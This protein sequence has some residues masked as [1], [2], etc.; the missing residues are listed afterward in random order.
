MEFSS[1][2]ARKVLD[3]NPRTFANWVSL[4]EPLRPA[5]GKGTRA[6]FSDRNLIE[7]ALI[8]LL[9]RYRFERWAVI[10]I[11]EDLRSDRCLKAYGDV[12]DLRNT[13]QQFLLVDWGV[14]RT[15]QT[16]NVGFTII[17]ELKSAYGREGA[18]FVIDF[19]V[20]REGLVEKIATL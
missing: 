4:I 14:T 19:L 9:F 15:D 1:S 17:E 7:L 18:F 6:V 11:M 8:G 5:R 16:V 2:Q 20:F 13:R 3:V 12:L 10:L